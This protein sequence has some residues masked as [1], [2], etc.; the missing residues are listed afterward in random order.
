MKA[1]TICCT[2]LGLKDLQLGITQVSILDD[3][4]WVYRNVS[5]IAVETIASDIQHTWGGRLCSS[6]TA[7][8]VLGRLFDAHQP[9]VD[10]SKQRQWHASQTPNMRLPTHLSS[11]V[12]VRFVDTLV[13]MKATICGIWRRQAAPIGCEAFVALRWFATRRKAT[14]AR[15]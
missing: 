13:V 5:C 4:K 15:I 11:T 2:Y 14:I 6:H 7:A 12:H 1:L 10:R 8:S 3:I 9:T